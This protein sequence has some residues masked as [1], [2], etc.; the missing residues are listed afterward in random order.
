MKIC[1][2]GEIEGPVETL[3]LEIVPEAITLSI[4]EGC[5]ISG[6]AEAQTV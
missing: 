1:I 6:A 2:D 3:T 5:S 4:P